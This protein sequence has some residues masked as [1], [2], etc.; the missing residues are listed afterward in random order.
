MSSK[1]VRL[2]QTQLAPLMLLVFIPPD[3]FQPRLFRCW[4]RYGDSFEDSLDQD[5]DAAL[6]SK[7]KAAKERAELRQNVKVRVLTLRGTLLT[8]VHI[9]L[10]L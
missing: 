6:S 3:I 9:T 5:G 2:V 7:A 8:S 1:N 10:T 4:E